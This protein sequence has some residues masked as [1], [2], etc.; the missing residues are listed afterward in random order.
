MFP[1]RFV[2]GQTVE[3]FLLHDRTGSRPN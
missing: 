1:L 2:V 3:S